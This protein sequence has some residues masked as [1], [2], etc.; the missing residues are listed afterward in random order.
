MKEVKKM[1]SIVFQ[2]D[3]KTGTKYAYESVSYWD[4]EKQQPRSKRKYIGKVD[5]ETGEIIKKEDRAKHSD[6]KTNTI[7]LSRLYEEIKNKEKTIEQL[8]EELKESKKENEKL[9]KIMRKIHSL[10]EVEI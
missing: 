2:V 7:E 8:T 1:S 5:P 9:I 10:V 6:N 4:K 3:K